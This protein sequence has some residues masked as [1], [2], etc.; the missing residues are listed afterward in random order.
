MS[1]RRP[2]AREI[3]PVIGE[4]GDVRKLSRNRGVGPAEALR[5]FR[6]QFRLLRVAHDHWRHGAGPA[7]IVAVQHVEQSADIARV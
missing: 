2:H 7:Q 4:E 5:Q 3:G 6:G 1:A